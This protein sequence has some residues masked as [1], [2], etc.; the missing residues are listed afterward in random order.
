MLVGFMRN[1]KYPPKIAKLTAQICS[2]YDLQL[3]YIRPQDVNIE[4]K[5]VKGKILKGTKWINVTRDLPKV[6]DM[7]QYCFKRKNRLIINFLR[8]NSYLTYDS[9]KIVSKEKLQTELF[10]DD[11][12]KHLVIPTKRIETIESIIEFLDKYPKSIIKPVAGE[13]GNNVYM[14]TK[15]HEDS[16]KLAYKKNESIISKLQL[17]EFFNN[18]ISKRRYIIQKYITS[19]TQ[20]GDPYDCR[21]V[22]QKNSHGKWVL[23]KSYMRIGVGQKV[24]SNISQGGGIR[25]SRSFLKANF[26]DDWKKI[27][28][29]IKGLVDHLPSKIEKLKEVQLMVLGL[30]LA[31]DK[32][33]KIYLLE[34][35]GAPRTA[36]LLG[37]AAM[38]NAQYYSYLMKTLY[39]EKIEEK[40]DAVQQLKDNISKLTKENQ[41]LKNENSTYKDKY[42]SV[43]QSKSWYVTRPFRKVISYI[44]K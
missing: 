33:G 43:L 19:R 15:N 42:N 6:I 7:S 32:S 12:L 29:E 10:K 36:N 2:H 37:E 11:R 5:T 14:L 27:E 8:V 30:D 1:V 38:L 13:K 16:F 3:I 18:E 35:N 25:E 44:K 31:I 4:N 20:E 28:D 9:N 26:E 24:T 39:H 17:D 21:V 34:S 23:A 41:K 22:V 40:N